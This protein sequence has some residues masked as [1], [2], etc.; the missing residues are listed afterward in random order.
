MGKVDIF[1][2]IDFCGKCQ[3]PRNLAGKLKVIR[4]NLGLSRRNLIMKLIL[5]V[6]HG[7][8][9]SACNL[10]VRQFIHGQEKNKVVGGTDILSHDA[11][12][13]GMF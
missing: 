2:I 10:Q 5:K 1:A 3:L 11:N 6:E 4:C 12:Q 9:F 7:K 8:S 13:T